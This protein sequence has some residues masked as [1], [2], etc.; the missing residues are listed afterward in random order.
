MF[1]ILKFILLFPTKIENAGATFIPEISN[2]VKDMAAKIKEDPLFLIRKKEEESKKEL[3]QNPIK[4]RKLKEMLN[5]SVKDKKKNK[6]S[7]KSKHKKDKKERKRRYE[8]DSESEEDNN[9]DHR[10]KKR[11]EKEYFIAENGHD[12]EKRQKNRGHERE[13]RRRRERSDSSDSNDNRHR[14]SSEGWRGG[15]RGDDARKGKKEDNYNEDAMERRIIQK[16]ETERR[17]TNERRNRMRETEKREERMSGRDKEVRSKNIV[18]NSRREES[19]KKRQQRRRSSSEE[20][21]DSSE[22]DR[23]RSRTDSYANGHSRGTKSGESREE[24]SYGLIHPKAKSERESKHKKTLE[25]SEDD[26]RPG[27]NGIRKNQI[28]D[29][30]S[31]VRH[32]HDSSSDSSPERHQANKKGWANGGQSSSYERSRDRREVKKANSPP[33]RMISKNLSR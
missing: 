3:V 30:R 32:R 23:G 12:V 13:K 20:E 2:P 29:G 8:S 25:G 26:S 6:K 22:D 24:C 31:K 10:S 14:Y 27:R 21:S 5:L 18:Y 17:D 28:R 1:L 16:R 33:S 4:L 7:K 11:K 15:N 9:E 19:D